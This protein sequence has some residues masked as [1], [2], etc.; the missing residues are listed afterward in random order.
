[1]AKAGP[2]GTL[3]PSRSCPAC[4]DFMAA[5]QDASQFEAQRTGARQMMIAERFLSLLGQLGVAWQES[6][7]NPALFCYRIGW[8][9][10]EP[11]R[12][13]ALP[14]GPQESCLPASNTS[15]IHSTTSED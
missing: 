7:E 4:D 9:V 3:S 2:E 12:E 8:Q 13:Q 14:K 10:V 15:C 5:T 1:M 11:F 6:G